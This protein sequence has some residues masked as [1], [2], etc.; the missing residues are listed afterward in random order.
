MKNADEAKR[1]RIRDEMLKDGLSRGVASPS[2]GAPCLVARTTK[3][4][5]YPTSAAQFFGC[6]PVAVMGNEVEGAAALLTPLSTT[7]LAINLGTAIP[8]QGTD[9]VTTFVGNR[10]VFRYDG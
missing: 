6:T 5:V 3:I 4:A 9:V 10:W 1:L 7:F 8:P 2:S